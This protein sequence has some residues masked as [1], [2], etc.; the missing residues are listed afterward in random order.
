MPEWYSY[1][2]REAN[3]QQ[4]YHRT[5]LLSQIDPKIWLKLCQW[6]TVRLIGNSET[7]G[8]DFLPKARVL[9]IDHT[10][11]S[12]LAL[13][14]FQIDY[15]YFIN[16]FLKKHSKYGRFRNQ[17]A[18]RFFLIFLIRFSPKSPYAMI[19]ENLF[20]SNNN[21]IAHILRKK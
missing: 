7:N 6:A 2:V 10:H 11:C 4:W 8:L 20:I 14:F 15:F 19:P 12:I 3:R 13:I 18:G 1:T 5:T 17:N 16:R 9:P 21:L